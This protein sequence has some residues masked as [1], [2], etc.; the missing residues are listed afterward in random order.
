[1]LARDTVIFSE[2]QITNNALEVADKQ[3]TCRP[4]AQFSKTD[5]L[6]R[7]T[8]QASTSIYCY[9]DIKLGVFLISVPAIYYHDFLNLFVTRRIILLHP[10]IEVVNT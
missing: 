7:D 2:L 4:T 9:T 8:L 5:R 3:D 6:E 1:M 10:L